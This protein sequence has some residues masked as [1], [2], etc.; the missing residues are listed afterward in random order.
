[1]KKDDDNLSEKVISGVN[2]ITKDKTPIVM[3]SFKIQFN[4]VK[5]KK[6]LTGINKIISNIPFKSWRA[7]VSFIKI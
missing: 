2:I 6:S 5:C 4:I 1:M 3:V 7:L